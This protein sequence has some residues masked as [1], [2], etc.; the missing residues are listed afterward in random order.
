MPIDPELDPQHR[1]AVI[2]GAGPGGSVAALLLARQGFAVTVLERAAAPSRGAG[3]GLL[4]Q[5]N[6]LAVLYGLGFRDRLQAKA[7]RISQATVR[8]GQG[9]PIVSVDLP[10]FGEGLDHALAMHRGHL[11]QVL[12]DALEDEPA[13][14]LITSA[15]VLAA[16]P[17][18]DVW[19]S[20]GDEDVR[21]VVADLVVGADGI[22][23]V[24]REGG[25]FG[26]RTRHTAR[27]YVR[28]L[29]NAHPDGPHGEFWTS[30]GLFGWAPL[31]DGSS[32]F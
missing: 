8:D 16:S 23:S 26:D 32:Y 13:I 21:H 28:G 20:C 9:R 19:Y 5:P 10:D 29:T 2:A 17:D 12:H 7:E 15:E 27:F 30:V 4:L 22:R 1:T 31:G 24:V 3:A 18:G 11:M 6:G 14:T 25:D